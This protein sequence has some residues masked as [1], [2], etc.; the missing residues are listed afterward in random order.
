M[1]DPINEPM[2]IF[3]KSISN[4]TAECLHLQH[5]QPR[6]MMTSEMNLHR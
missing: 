6:E 4:A 1:D 2:N 3:E 5:L